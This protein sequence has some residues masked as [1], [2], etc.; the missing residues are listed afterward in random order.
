MRP[1]RAS[2]PMTIAVIAPLRHP[3]GEPHAGGLEA[4]VHQRIR[5]LRARGHRVLVAAVAGS[6]P[7]PQPAALALPAVR[8]SPGESP[9]DSTYPAGYLDD[10]AEALDGA[11]DWLEDHADVVD[12]I[13]NHCLH[14]LPLERARGHAVPQVTTLHTPPFPEMVDAAL[15]TSSRL[16]AVSGWT[17]AEWA[18]AGVTGVEVLHNT[19]DESIWRQGR[20]GGDLVWFGRLV[21]EKA[22]HLA[23]AAARSV[24]RTLVLAGRIGDEP[25]FR[26]VIEP[27]LAAD[28]RY[29]GELKAGELARLV[30]ASA[31]TLVT[32]DWDEPF[33]LVLAEALAT[34][35]PV[36][37]FARGGLP[38]VAGRNPGV[39][40]A[41]AGDVLA[42]GRAADE[43]ARGDSAPSRRVVR[44]EA[45]RRFSSRR[46]VV[47]IERLF[48]GVAAG[49]RRVES[50]DG[51][52]A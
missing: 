5:L 9:T 43:L 15:G 6:E 49:G 39:R 42:L 36:A 45:L 51:V 37:A 28:V 44:A 52:G 26:T 30:G 18:Q 33:G 47:D 46:K 24:G 20:G 4:A 48:A 2:S 22:P 11:Y 14:P 34:G 41:A 25:Y 27:L 29:A 16:V 35:T 13:D 7:A 38:E 10:A 21:P 32:P 40:F 1:G 17:A 50:L 23:V 12:V 3:L 31:A 19:I 8:W